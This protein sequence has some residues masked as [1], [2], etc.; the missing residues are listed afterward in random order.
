[1]ISNSD[2]IHDGNIEAKGR[3][4]ISKSDLVLDHNIK[5]KG[6]VEQHIC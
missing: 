5:A 6:G 2:F 1:M 4:L 3:V